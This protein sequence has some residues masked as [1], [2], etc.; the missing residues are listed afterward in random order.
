MATANIRRCPQ[1][2][3][4]KLTGALVGMD[5]NLPTDDCYISES[6]L[7]QFLDVSPRTLYGWRMAGL[8]PYYKIGG[9]IRFKLRE[10]EESLKAHN[11]VGPVAA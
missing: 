10:V 1:I 5:A 2:A 11:R 4:T 8:I 6:K 3:A 7:S 9:S